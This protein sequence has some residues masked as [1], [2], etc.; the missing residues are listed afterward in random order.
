M[1]D[2]T[3]T[4]EGVVTY[5]NYM[6]DDFSTYSGDVWGGRVNVI[7]EEQAKA[8]EVGTHVRATW[9]EPCDDRLW[10]L[11]RYAEELQDI[12]TNYAAVPGEVRLVFGFDS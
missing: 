10:A 11:K 3:Y 9:Q 8:G 2:K 7:T 12:A 4:I 6:R 1:K 5:D